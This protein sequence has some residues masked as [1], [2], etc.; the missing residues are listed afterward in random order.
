MQA[1]LFAKHGKPGL[2][3][4]KIMEKIGRERLLRGIFLIALTLILIGQILNLLLDFTPRVRYIL[5]TTM[6]CLIGIGYIAESF[7]KY[8]KVK[9]FVILFSGL[10]LVFMNFIPMS[11]SFYIVAAVCLVAPAIIIRFTKPAKNAASTGDGD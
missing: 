1:D 5:N 10:F 8:H 7:G 11:V 2:S 3:K 9:R 4:I 6:F